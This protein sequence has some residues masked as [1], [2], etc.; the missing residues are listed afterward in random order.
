VGWGSGGI[1]ASFLTS[2][3]DSEWLYSRS[4]RSTRKETAPGIHCIGAYMGLRAGLDT[5]E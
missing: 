1:A 2:E 3:L 5:V 4:G